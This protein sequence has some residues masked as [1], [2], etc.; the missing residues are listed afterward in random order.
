MSPSEGSRIECPD[1]GSQKITTAEEVKCDCGRYYTHHTG[2]VTR[3]SNSWKIQ[4]LSKEGPQHLS[5]LN[6]KLTSIQ[7]QVVSRIKVPGTR[8]IV[9]YLIGDER[10]AADFI[11]KN[12]EGLVE[13]A[14]ESD[15]NHEIRQNLDDY[16]FD[17]VEQQYH[18][19]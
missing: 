3:L 8:H 18:W 1:C 15:R 19:G 2:L 14:L 12:H 13:N 4:K 7:K 17:L 5:D 9:V 11:V 16:M 10:R 6:D